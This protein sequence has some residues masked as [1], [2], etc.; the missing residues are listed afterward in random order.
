MTIPTSGNDGTAK[1]SMDGH[2]YAHKHSG[3][4]V[5]YD[6]HAMQMNEMSEKTYAP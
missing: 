1:D 4:G 5:T 3:D 6:P 2:L